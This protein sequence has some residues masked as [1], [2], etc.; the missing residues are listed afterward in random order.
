MRGVEH[1]RYAAMS[2]SHRAAPACVFKS[3]GANASPLRSAGN[4]QKHQMRVRRM[5]MVRA[6]VPCRQCQSRAACRRRR[7]STASAA[8]APTLRRNVKSKAFLPGA[9]QI[10]PPSRSPSLS[11]TYRFALGMHGVGD[12]GVEELAA[13]ALFR[14]RPASTNNSARP[15]R[16]THRSAPRPCAWFSSAPRQAHDRAAR[17]YLFR[18]ADGG[19]AAEL[20]QRRQ[21]AVAGRV[22]RALLDR[23]FLVANLVLAEAI[24]DVA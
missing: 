16:R 13:R 14:A 1:S 21:H 18:D 20:D 24:D 3:R 23:G 22:A 2:W 15:H 6:R 19:A 8:S 4:A 10:A 12:D 9:S 7:R 11:A 17:S 5:R